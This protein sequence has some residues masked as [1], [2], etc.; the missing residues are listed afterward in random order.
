MQENVHATGKPNM[1]AS[2]LEQ[3]AMAISTSKNCAIFAFI[4]Y[5]S[6]TIYNMHAI[7]S[8]LR[9]LARNQLLQGRSTFEKRHGFK[10]LKVNDVF[11]HTAKEQKNKNLVPLSCMQK[12][13][14]TCAMHGIACH[15][16]ATQLCQN[17][18][19]ARP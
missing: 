18:C 5:N 10:D 14:S 16:L 3:A 12:H 2:S 9:G 8:C 11:L 19:E 6:E 1:H 15:I 4:A 7:K 13:S 17:G